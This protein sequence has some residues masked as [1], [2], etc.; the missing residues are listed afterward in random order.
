MSSFASIQQIQKTHFIN[1]KKFKPGEQVS[2]IDRETKDR[3]KTRRFLSPF[4]TSILK[5]AIFSPLSPG[6]FF[7][8]SNWFPP[9]PTALAGC[10]VTRA[11]KQKVHIYIKNKYKL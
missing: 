8:F 10:Q 2:Q 5:Q 1:A 11:P 7:F 4:P 9:H 3:I 6:V